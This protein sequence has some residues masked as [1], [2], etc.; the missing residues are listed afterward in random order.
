M[1]NTVSQSCTK[2]GEE[3]EEGRVLRRIVNGIFLMP[4]AERYGED[5]GQ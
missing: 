4:T 5:Q 2:K 3:E 1:E